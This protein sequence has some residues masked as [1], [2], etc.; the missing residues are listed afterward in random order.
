V[1]AYVIFYD[2]FQGAYLKFWIFLKKNL[3]NS[4][5]SGYPLFWLGI[6][7]K[8]TTGHILCV[9]TNLIL[10]REFRI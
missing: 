2:F 5:W 3:K 7:W 8:A 6:S 1:S 10:K 4:K 9:V